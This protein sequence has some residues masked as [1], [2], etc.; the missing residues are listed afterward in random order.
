M[1]EPSLREPSGPPDAI[2]TAVAHGGWLA[3]VAALSS[4]RYGT[5][6]LGAIAFAD[7]SFL[8]IPPD[9]MLVPMILFRP[10]RLWWL[11]AICT[12]GST[13][14]AAVGYLIGYFLWQTLGEPLVEFYG[15]MHHYL[16]FRGWVEDWGAPVIIIKALTPI[17]FK[18]AAIA[19]GAAQMNPVVFMLASFVGRALHFAMV[20]GL[21][22]FF[23]P[24]IIALIARYERPMIVVSLLALIGFGMYWALR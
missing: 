2:S 15:H 12:V 21:L 13:L 3:R 4:H 18:I 17:P 14:G 19:A 5:W 11:L 22:V 20:A 7:S 9:L 8:P 1:V 16:V 6:L 23:G 10:E 24:R